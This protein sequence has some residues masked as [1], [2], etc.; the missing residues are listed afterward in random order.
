MRRFR[1]NYGS[2]PPHRFGGSGW[3][4][5]RIVDLS[6]YLGS[7]QP[8]V[9]NEG[10]AVTLFALEEGGVAVFS[11]EQVGSSTELRGGPGGGDAGSTDVRVR[12]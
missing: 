1:F 6:L 10:D 2:E 9:I 11:L 4:A 7:A 3:R 8:L 5:L 12:L